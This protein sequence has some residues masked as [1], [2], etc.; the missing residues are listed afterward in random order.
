MSRNHD[1]LGLSIK[2]SAA[3]EPHRHHFVPEFYLSEWNEPGTGKFCLYFRD[4]K[5]KISLRNRSARAVGYE[6]H[7]YSYVPDGLD[8]RNTKSAQLETSYQAPCDHVPIRSWPLYRAKAVM[9]SVVEAIKVEQ[10]A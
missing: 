7:L 3:Q 9:G 5:G 6:D 4:P 10:R 2:M 8:F 1:W